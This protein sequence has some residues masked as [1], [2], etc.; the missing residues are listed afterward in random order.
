MNRLGHQAAAQATWLGVCTFE[1]LV[2][3]TPLTWQ[4]VLAGAIVASSMCADDWS[5]DADQGGYMAKIIPGG[6]RGPT[7]MPEL[8]AAVLFLLG[9]VAGQDL[10]W[11]VAAAAAAWGS[12]LFVDFF[13][14]GIP[15]GI[16]TLAG[17]KK[18]IG[19]KLDTGGPAEEVVT[20]GLT[21]IAIP[22]A[23]IALGGPL[24][25]QVPL[26]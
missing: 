12:H 1:R 2:V 14:G 18:R 15:F 10:D 16:A 19:F 23:Y 22:L 7:H 4:H 25:V 13:W 9:R 17:N 6:H 11:F 21:C 5:P 3:D 8:V 26:T 20:T 24:P